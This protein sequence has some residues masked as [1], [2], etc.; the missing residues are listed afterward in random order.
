MNI[1]YKGCTI[2][3][4]TTDDIDSIMAL[5]KQVILDLEDKSLLREN[6]AEMFTSCVNFPNL[7]LGI[8]NP[9]EELVALGILCDMRGTNEDLSLGLL[10]HTVDVSANLKLIM[11]RKD[12]RGLGMQNKLMSLL[13]EY[14]RNNGYTH[15]CTTVSPNNIHSLRNIENMGYVYDH[16]EEKYGGL[17]RSVLVKKLI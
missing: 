12:F 11:V 15:L 7:T 8:F 5:Q 4:C 17:L 14:A 9:T 3:Q 10:Q 16:S 1:L 6:N 2:R 13:E